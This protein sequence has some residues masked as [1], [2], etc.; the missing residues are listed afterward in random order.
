MK[1]MPWLVILYAFI[2]MGG[3]MMGYYKAGSLPSLLMGCMTGLILI[4]SAITMFNKEVLGYFVSCGVAF[5]MAI[6]FTYRFIG[7]FKL[8]PTGLMAAISFLVFV[9]MVAVKLKN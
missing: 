9:T 8:L 6:F 7:S 2:L 5:A 4:V 1:F 3:G